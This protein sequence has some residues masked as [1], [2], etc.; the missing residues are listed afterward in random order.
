MKELAK[1]SWNYILSEN[2]SGDLIFS[3]I[4]GSVGLYDIK[5][6]LIADEINQYRKE[7]KLYLATL[8]NEIRNHESRFDARKI[9]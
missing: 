8:A 2:E 5:I 6:R 4:S 3:V 1:E 7:G 9:A